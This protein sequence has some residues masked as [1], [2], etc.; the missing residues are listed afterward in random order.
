MLVSPTQKSSPILHITLGSCCCT[1]ETLMVIAPK[2]ISR[3]L[4]LEPDTSSSAEDTE[5]PALPS[6]LSTGHTPVQPSNG[7][8]PA[9]RVQPSHLFKFRNNTV[10]FHTPGPG[11]FDPSA[12]ASLATAPIGNGT[13]GEVEVE[14]KKKRKSEKGET[15][16]PKKKKKTKA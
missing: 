13:S 11:K 3:H 10:G 8:T 12:V 1:G 15:E 6:F 2:P 4:V 7:S 5:S 14:K 9:K 16:T